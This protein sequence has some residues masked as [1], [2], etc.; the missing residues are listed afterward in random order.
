MHSVSVLHS[1]AWITL[2]RAPRLTLHPA[3]AR[4]DQSR[5]LGVSRGRASRRGW[6]CR[7]TGPCRTSCRSRPAA[8]SLHP[9]T[10]P[11]QPTGN[12]LS[13]GTCTPSFSK[14]VGLLYRSAGAPW[15]VRSVPLCTAIACFP[16]PV[17]FFPQCAGV[18]RSPAAWKV[19][20]TML[21]FTWPCLQR[22]QSHSPSRPRCCL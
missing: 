17:V 7:S 16:E 3:S 20:S 15:S 6:C 5:G 8:C 22:S 4:T 10:Q 2:R 19:L 18:A 1:C 14:G 12:E 13:G 11:S 9:T 21:T